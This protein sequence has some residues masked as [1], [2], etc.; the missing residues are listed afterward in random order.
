MN[1]KMSAVETSNVEYQNIFFNIV[2]M[3]LITKMQYYYRRM[4]ISQILI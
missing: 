1:T 3:S 4:R 2:E